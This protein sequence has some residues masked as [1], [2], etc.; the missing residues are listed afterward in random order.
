[1]SDYENIIHRPSSSV[2]Q[3]SDGIQEEQ[4]ESFSSYILHSIPELK[5]T[6]SHVLIGD[7]LPS[8]LPRSRD[9]LPNEIRGIDNEIED[10]EIMYEDFHSRDDLTK[11]SH[12][13]LLIRHLIMQRNTLKAT[14]QS[15]EKVDEWQLDNTISNNGEV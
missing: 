9:F 3:D 11:A 8:G 10:L 2:S 7:T 13:D 1:M 15:Y 4:E 12:V 5:K 14:L 6:A